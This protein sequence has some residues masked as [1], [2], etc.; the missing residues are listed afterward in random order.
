MATLA[1]I[2][3]YSLNDNE[4]EDSFSFLPLL[5][6]EEPEAL[7]APIILHS[8]NGMFA[9]REDK[10]KMVFGNGSGGREVPI[11]MNNIRDNQSS[12]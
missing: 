5:L 2:T 3:G 9:I 6:G 10:W 12:K 1:D 8:G 11:E 7:R 4:G